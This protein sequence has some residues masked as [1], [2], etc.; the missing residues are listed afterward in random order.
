MLI[1][2]ALVAL[3][4]QARAPWV[5]ERRASV[6]AAA[7]AASGAETFDDVAALV[8]IGERESAWRVSVGVCAVPG[9]GGWGYFGVAGLW[10]RRFPGGTCGS[11]QLQARAALGIMR[12]GAGRSWRTTFGHYIGAI[13]AGRH[14]EAI[15]RARDFEA[16]RALLVWH[17]DRLARE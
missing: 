10:S 1:S 3:V 12:I 6:L 17:A 5:P 13:S 8:V 4:I 14:P 11:P 7:I 9:I 15:R 16:T 2:P